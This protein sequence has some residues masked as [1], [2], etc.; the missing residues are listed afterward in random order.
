MY[1]LF[2]SRTLPKA[3]MPAAV[4]VIAAFSVERTKKASLPCTTFILFLGLHFFLQIPCVQ[5][6]CS[7]RI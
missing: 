6:D 4:T 5:D 3:V 1:A 7:P 2:G